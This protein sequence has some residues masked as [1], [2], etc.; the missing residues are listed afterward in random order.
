MEGE[1]SLQ[2]KTEKMTGLNCRESAN[3]KSN[4]GSTQS[5]SFDLQRLFV[6]VTMKYSGQCI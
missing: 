4:R 3:C 5:H 2:R 1:A 6:Y